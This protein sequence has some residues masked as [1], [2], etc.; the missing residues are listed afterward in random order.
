[1]SPGL[2]TGRGNEMLQHPMGGGRLDAG[3]LSAK[4]GASKKNKPLWRPELA[5]GW[6]LGMRLP[7]RMLVCALSYVKVSIH[8]PQLGHLL[9]AQNQPSL[10]A[11]MFL[12]TQADGFHL[13]G[14]VWLV[15]N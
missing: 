15:R 5:S 14:Q 3:A 11:D 13:I 6:I 8:G 2:K 4:P 10:E 1:M 9:Q 12:H 7:W